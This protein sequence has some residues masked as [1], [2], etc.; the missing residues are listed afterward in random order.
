[1]SFNGWKKIHL[2]EVADV[3]TGPFGSQLHQREYVLSGTP[4][5]TVEHLGENYL[6]HE[7]LPMVS[8]EDK[9][10]LSKYSLKEG[11]I[12][13]SR[14]GSVDRR[15]YV[16]KEEEGW[17]FSGRCL[18]VRP[19]SEQV[20]GRYLSYYFGLSSFKE[21]IR[22][23]AVGSTM[24]SLNTTILSD[25]EIPL[26]PIQVQ[27][28]IVEILSSLDDKIE[29]NRKTNETLEAIA[30]AIFKEWFV[31]NEK[32]KNWGSLPL[33]EIIEV[34]PNRKLKNGQLA[35]YLDMANMPT[36]GHRA[37]GWIQRPFGS[38]TKFTNGDT[39]LARITPCLEN[40]KTA[41]VDF[42]EEGQTGWGSTEYIIFRPK[43]PPSP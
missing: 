16:K 37:N 12:V 8:E 35:P 26:P 11:D 1:M 32:A 5:I 28:N 33:P 38:G 23:I 21:Y 6:L 24:P 27:H 30:Q 14:V 39:L 13:F 34:N 3:Q 36:K 41:F 25:I 19:I 18:R 4:I 22:A 17:L 10:R 42:L 15:A 31:D 9:E 29:L 20:N 2:K 43:P 7:D 40:G